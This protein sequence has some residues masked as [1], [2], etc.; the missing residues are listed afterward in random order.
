MTITLKIENSVE[1][2]KEHEDY[3]EKVEIYKNKIK[4]IVKEQYETI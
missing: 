2:N 1:N 4:K 3:L